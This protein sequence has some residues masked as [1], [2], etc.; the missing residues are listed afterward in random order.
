MAPNAR[1]KSERWPARV[2]APVRTGVGR[3]S[4]GLVINR[5]CVVRP[6]SGRAWGGREA[7]VS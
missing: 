7:P 2:R 6:R 1:A 4:P 3:D 5:E